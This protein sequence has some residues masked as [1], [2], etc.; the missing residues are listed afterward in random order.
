[1]WDEAGAAVKPLLVG[2]ANPYQSDP[3]LA[4]R[5]ALYPDPPGCAGWNLCHRIMQLDEAEYL[6]RFD[7]VNLCAGKWSMREARAKADEI[8]IQDRT[9]VLF[10]AKASSAFGWVKFNEAVFRWF[11]A[12]RGAPDFVI[13]PHPSGLSRAWNEPGAHER[14]RAVLREAGVL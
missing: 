13:L 9:L 12:N 6:A 2:E 4:Q 1:M 5:Y 11:Q 10:G 14:A 3:R 7:R 8:K